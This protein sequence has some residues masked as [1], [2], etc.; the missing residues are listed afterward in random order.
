MLI[1][2]VSIWSWLERLGGLGLIVVGLA[3]NSPFPIPGSMDVLTVILSARQKDWWPY[4]SAMATIGAVVG[5]YLTYSL[6]RKGGE[7]EFE[8]RLPKEKAEK[9]YK[10]FD[11]Y[12]FWTLFVPALL[13]PPIPFSPFLIGAGAL[14][15][16][17][18]RFVVAV[19][20]GRAIRYGALGYLTSR[21]SSHILGF[22]Q[23]YSQPIL[24]TFIILA[25]LGGVTAA[26]YVWRRKRRGKTVHD[27]QPKEPAK[28]A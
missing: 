27:S 1:L 12:G 21:Y 19:T 28:V 3:D 4:Y 11:R 8:R 6:G 22:F 17:P 23:K 14:Q 7:E 24:L 26:L 2:A 16:P 15:Y 20:L 10:A 9:V 18:R 13:P 5:G 25:V